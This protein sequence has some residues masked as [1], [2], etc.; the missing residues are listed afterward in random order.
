M[1]QVRWKPGGSVGLFLNAEGN[2]IMD[3]AEK[4][5]VFNASF[6]SVSMKKVHYQMTVGRKTI[7]G[8]ESG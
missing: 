1:L 3:D 2:L 5:E 8:D 6:T 4:V 7:E